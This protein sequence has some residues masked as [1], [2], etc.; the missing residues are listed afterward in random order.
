M[1][2]IIRDVVVLPLVPVTAMTGIFG[3]M[4][5]GAAP[6]SDPATF[7]AAAPTA[8]SMSALGKESSTSA[9]ARP[10]AWPR[11]RRRHG[12][13]T[14]SWW[15]SLVGRT[16]TASR[17]VP[18]SAAIA[19]T[20]RATARAAKRWRNPVSEAPGR[21]F[22]RPIRRANRTAVSSGTAARPLMSSVSLIV[23]RGK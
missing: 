8:P 13:A 3:V 12:K 15:G 11:S 7:N 10:M 4:V 21:A 19:R 9:T 23:A 14:T 2:A 20:S 1:W 5:L 22:R 18:D 16:R 6:G 17:D